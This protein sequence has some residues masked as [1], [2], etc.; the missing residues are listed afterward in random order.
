TFGNFVVERDTPGY[1]FGPKLRGIGWKGLDT[2]ELVFDDVFVPDAHQLGD[3]GQGLAQFLE[4]LEVGR[5]SIA[6]LSISL[7]RAVLDLAQRYARERTQFGRPIGDFQAIQF[8][9]ADIAT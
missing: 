9:L 1:S 4:V 3:A 6:A 7:T 8:K 5:I 2:R